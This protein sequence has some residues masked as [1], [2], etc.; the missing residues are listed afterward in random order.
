M[1]LVRI[2]LRQGKKH[3]FYKSIADGLATSPGI[4]TE[5]VFISLAQ[6]AA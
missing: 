5:D 6:Y 3:R 2:D 1:P 4:R